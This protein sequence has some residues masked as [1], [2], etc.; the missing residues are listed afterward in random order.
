MAIRPVFTPACTLPLSVIESEIEFTWYPGFSINQTRKSI[1]SLHE[2]AKKKLGINR[3]LEVS[4]KSDNPLGV[5]LSAFNLTFTTKKYEQKYTVESVFQGSKVFEKGGPYTDLYKLNSRKA[6]TDARL[7]ESGALIAFRFFGKD[8]PLEPKTLFYDWI[9][10]N[11]LSQHE[12]LSQDIFQYDAF[13]DIAFNPMKSF[14]CQ[15]RSVAVYI[16]LKKNRQLLEAL[17]SVESF[18]RILSSYYQKPL[19]T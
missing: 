4:S 14:S 3:I 7:K 6:K 17:E 15:A 2:Q 12:D 16:C 9:Y 19:G 11:A 18:F 10:V 1:D 8:F 5:R 13:T